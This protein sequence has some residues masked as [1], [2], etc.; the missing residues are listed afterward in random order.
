MNGLRVGPNV[1]Y[2]LDFPT[3]HLKSNSATVNNHPSVDDSQI[4]DT[5]DEFGISALSLSMI[6]E[7]FFE[8]RLLHPKQLKNLP[9][10][11]ILS[12][13]YL[14]TAIMKL[15]YWHQVTIVGFIK[16]KSRFAA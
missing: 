3:F 16:L 10:S 4:T 1:H 7:C 6:K 5:K 12:I 9:N 2:V 14:F 11:L 15:C 13:V 8:F